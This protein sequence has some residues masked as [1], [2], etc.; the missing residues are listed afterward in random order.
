MDLA[1]NLKSMSE[2]V[3]RHTSPWR[4]VPGEFIEK[5]SKGSVAKPTKLDTF[6]SRPFVFPV[7]K[8]L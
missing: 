3:I 4:T 7:N 2:L 5:N 8:M 6:T 1:G